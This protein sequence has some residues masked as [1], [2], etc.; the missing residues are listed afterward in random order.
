MCFFIRKANKDKLQEAIRDFRDA[1]LI[2]PK[3]RNGT[4][5]LIETLLSFAKRYSEN[6]PISGYCST[7]CQCFALFCANRF[8]ILENTEKRA[9]ISGRVLAH[10]SPML[11]FLTFSGGIEM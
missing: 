11:H 8:R 1:L 10:F 9:T 2:N 5:Y 4:S 6:H 3:H 7:Q